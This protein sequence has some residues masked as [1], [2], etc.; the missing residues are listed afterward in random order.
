MYLSGPLF[1]PNG[2]G[3]STLLLNGEHP[4]VLVSAA[5]PDGVS[6]EVNADTVSPQLWMWFAV[7]GVEKEVEAWDDGRARAES[8]ENGGIRGRAWLITVLHHRRA[9]L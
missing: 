6:V 3:G 9:W 1:G 2:E 7:E 4:V 8:G 5:A